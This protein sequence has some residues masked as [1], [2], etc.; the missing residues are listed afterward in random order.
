MTCGVFV[1]LTGCIYLAF[2]IQQKD[3]RVPNVDQMSGSILI[4]CDIFSLQCTQ[5]MHPKMAPYSLHW[6][7][8]VHYVGNSV[9]F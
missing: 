6:S 2:E 1:V 3:N 8:V 5:R 7:E 4:F 9:P